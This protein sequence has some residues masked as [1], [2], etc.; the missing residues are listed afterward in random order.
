MTTCPNCHVKML[1]NPI[2]N[3]QP[4]WCPRCGG[5]EYVS[6]NGHR[7]HVAVT[8]ASECTCVDYPDGR[9]RTCPTC[10][11]RAQRTTVPF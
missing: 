10:R 5:H 8:V 4:F 6:S 1:S 2:A 11:E 9:Q 3:G 7:K